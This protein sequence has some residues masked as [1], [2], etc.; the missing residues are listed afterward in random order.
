MTNFSY[1]AYDAQGAK[2][3]GQIEALTI[4]EARQL[5]HERDLMITSIAEDKKNSNEV[6]LFARRRVSSQELEYLTSELAL[7]LNSG[8][9]IDRGLSVIKR[10]TVSAP[11]S[12]LVGGL[13]DAV[14]R[15]ES[16]SDAM[17]AE[18]DIFGALYINLVKLG[19]SSGTLPNVF[20]RLAEDIKF[21]SQLRRKIVQALVYPTVIFTVC[22]FCILFIFNYIVNQI[23][24]LFSL[25][26]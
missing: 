11:Q 19:E 22:I 7:L 8:V 13:H 10:N 4:D 6:Y 26:Y 3:G 17:S 14:R 15:G 25:F 2:I 16:L 20:T 24:V 18:G 23:S 21:Q 1:S 9:T 5:L 12:K